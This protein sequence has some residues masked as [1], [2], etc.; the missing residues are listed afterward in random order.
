[1]LADPRRPLFWPELLIPTGVLAVLVWTLACA[2]PLDAW[3][4]PRLASAYALRLGLDLYPDLRSGAQLCWLYGPVFPLWMLPVTFMPSLAWAEALAVLLNAGA[5]LFALAWCLRGDTDGWRPALTRTAWAAL[6]LTS[7]SLTGGWFGGL[8]VDPPCI[9]LM[10][11][12]L[13]AA[14]R[15]LRNGARR[16]L[17]A[18]ATAAVLACWTK[19]TA[20][21]FP[22]VLAAVW[23]WERRGRL[24]AVW[25]LLV[26]AYGAV[27]SALVGGVFGFDRVWF[28]VFAIHLLLPWRDVTEYFAEKGP[29]LALDFLPWVALAWLPALWRRLCPGPATGS[30][31]IHAWLGLLMLPFGLAAMLK[32]GGGINSAHGLFFLGVAIGLR[33]HATTW[34]APVRLVVMALGSVLALAGAADRWEH[35]TPSP[36][37]DHLLAIARQHAGRLYLPWNPLP[38]LLT[39]GRIYPF[40]YALFAR[41]I[42]GTE[43]IAPEIRAA[44]PPEPVVVYDPLAPTRDIA[45]YLPEAKPLTLQALT[46]PGGP[47]SI[48]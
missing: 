15:Y 20:A 27:S 21:V 16:W 48:P 43:L 38:T 22:A 5:P 6:V 19:Q 7:A 29:I 9:A 11:V 17:H 14:R 18:A 37:Q 1:M 12:S 34:P 47:R 26:L 24:V 46:R 4:Q 31:S 45:R 2:A 41:E 40:E 33:L 36:Y 28:H 35:R 23:A 39:D 10:L 8:H 25:S 42:T 3:V 13:G 30:A 44:L 32:E